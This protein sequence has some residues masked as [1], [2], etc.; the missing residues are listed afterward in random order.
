EDGRLTTWLH[1]CATARQLGMQSTGHAERGTSAPP[2][3]ANTNL[4]LAPGKLTPA[5]LMADIKEGLYVIEL[6]GMGINGVTGDYSR[7]AAGYLIRNGQIAEPV[8]EITIAGNLKEM[9]AQ[10]TP[11]NDLVFRLATNSPT[12]RIDSMAIAGR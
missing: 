9:F 2:S 11:A 12:V 10:L 4:H 8:S 6:S 1:D 7:G 5:E 3:P